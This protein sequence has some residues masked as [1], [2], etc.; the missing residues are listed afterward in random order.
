MNA[1]DVLGRRER[2]SVTEADKTISG[3]CGQDDLLPEVPWHSSGT[4]QLD[5]IESRDLRS[6]LWNDEIEMESSR[7][8]VPLAQELIEF[9]DDFPCV[10]LNACNGLGEEA[11]V[12]APGSLHCA[13]DQVP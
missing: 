12:D 10:A 9:A 7:Q 3:K 1:N 6:S 11:A 8:R 2:A 4:S 13:F 5:R